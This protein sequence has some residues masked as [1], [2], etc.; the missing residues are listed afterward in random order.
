MSSL[1][2]LRENK[3]LILFPILSGISMVVVL[4]SFV[5]AVFASSGWDADNLNISPAIFY[6]LMFLLYIVIYF[7][8][9]FFNAALIHCAKLYF[10][11]QKPAL[12][13]GLAFSRSRI[14]VIFA[15]AVIA[16][17]V[18]IVL[19]AVQ[20]RLGFVGRLVTGLIGMLWS[21]ATFFVVPVLVYESAGPVDAIKRSSQLVREKWGESL[22]AGLGFGIIRL[23]AV[24]LVCGLL[25][26]LGFFIHPL[27]GIG[28]A[29]VGLIAVMAVLN[30]AETIFVSAVYHHVTG[31]PVE[32]FNEQMVNNLF[33]K[34]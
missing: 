9:I 29:V 16:A 25:F 24:F 27:L 4:A 31:D 33:E 28:L 1:K 13:D 17:T 11:G 23:L 8:T 18:G 20:D 12:S 30:A 2:V 22:G 34:Q 3:Q 14:G 10:Q 5:V 15:W 32:H 19:R 21:V 26:L 7:I 6:S